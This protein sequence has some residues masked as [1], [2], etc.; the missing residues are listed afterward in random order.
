MRWFPEALKDAVYKWWPNIELFVEN[1][2]FPMCNI[3][4]QRANGRPPIPVWPYSAPTLPASNIVSITTNGLYQGK[5]AILAPIHSLLL[6]ARGLR[7]LVLDGQPSPFP[8][9]NKT[10]P[11][12]KELWLL[13]G[14]MWPYAPDEVLK[15]WDLSRL[16]FLEMSWFR[17]D[18]FLASVNLGSFN[19]LKTLRIDYEGEQ[20]RFKYARETDG[21]IYH[22]TRMEA[23]VRLHESLIASQF[24][25][26]VFGCKR[27]G[28]EHPYDLHPLLELKFCKFQYVIHK[29]NY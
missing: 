1:L 24:Q 8:I 4:R 10:L 5:G 19:C 6:E 25:V 7:S 15:I 21:I 27:V 2:A 13:K 18:S 22:Q 12:L 11:P 23:L 16:E 20:G 28:K 17:L 3:I 14:A 9:S 29:G 26:W